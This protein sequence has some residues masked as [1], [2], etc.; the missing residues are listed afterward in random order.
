LKD[1]KVT[2]EL[3]AFLTHAQQVTN[4]FFAEGATTPKLRYVLRP[5]PGDAIGFK[6]KLDGKELDSQN[7]LRST[8]FW[9]APP[10]TEGGAEGNI[11]IRGTPVGFGYFP[12]MMW[13]VFRFFQIADDRPL[14]SRDVQWSKNR[15]LSGEPQPLPAPVKVHFVEFAGEVD[16]F[17]PKF[18]ETLQCPK[19]AVVPE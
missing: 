4:A 7:A 18:F 10:G 1:V 5:V 2:P 14:N 12:K 15:G 13:G 17:N 16:I 3:V 9:P 8:F 6:L 19:K 11:V